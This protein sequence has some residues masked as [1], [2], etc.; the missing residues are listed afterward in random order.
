M[1]KVGKEIIN[2]YFTR[3]MEFGEA[4]RNFDAFSFRKKTNRFLNLENDRVNKNSEEDLEK[5]IIENSALAELKKYYE[6]I[7]EY[8]IVGEENGFF[9]KPEM[10]MNKLSITQ[11]ERVLVYLYI[12]YYFYEGYSFENGKKDM[13]KK[14]SYFTGEP[15]LEIYA[16]LA[17][18]SKL[19]R[20]GLLA[21][22]DFNSERI[23]IGSEIVKYFLPIRDS[24][25]KK[26]FKK[27]IDSIYGSNLNPNFPQKLYSYLRSYVIGQDEAL[28]QISVSI[29]RHMLACVSKRENEKTVKGN[30]LMIGPTGT[31]KSYI[32]YLISKFLKVPFVKVNATQYTETGYVGLNV[33]DMIVKLYEESEGDE[34]LARNGIIFIDE[35]DKIAAQGSFYQHYSN[36]DVSGRCV[37]EELLKILEEDEVIYG[38]DHGVRIFREVKGYDISNVL[39]IAAGAFVG[40]DKII[41]ERIK[42]KTPIGFSS[43]KESGLELSKQVSNADLENF[44]FI[45][46]IIGRFPSIIA[47]KN[48]SEKDL[49]NILKQSKDSPIKLYEKMLEKSGI[50][51]K[52]DDKVIAEIAEEA[53]KMDTGAR[54]LYSIMEKKFFEILKNNLKI[55]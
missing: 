24:N 2:G 3:I 14:I 49:E 9:L 39:F 44:G 17:R 7:R 37:Q 25:K 42:N 23:E 53:N 28:K 46:E 32:A 10:K 16:S 38:H 26:I 1:K 48:L 15:M 11:S 33:E 41:E 12:Y 18:D 47:L 40:L 54:S 34:R 45:P 13:I 31:G 5:E 20:S 29:Y 22:K 8:V 50:D 21:Y 4:F 35:I 19:V 6:K 30:I 51:Y 27:E 52:F 43:S 36:K 55:C